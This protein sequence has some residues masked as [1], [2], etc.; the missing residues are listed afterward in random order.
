MGDSV[1][2]LAVLGSTGSIGRQTLQ[3][4]R[5]LSSRFRVVA[6]T[7]GHNAVLLTEQIGEFRPKFVHCASENAGRLPAGGPKVLSPE[8]IASLDEVDCVVVAISGGAALAATLAAVRAGKEAGAGWNFIGGVLP[9][10][11]MERF[12]AARG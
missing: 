8:E 11:G 12:A 5:R 10:A 4:V 6:L 3:V 1:K 2:R 7:A 9:F